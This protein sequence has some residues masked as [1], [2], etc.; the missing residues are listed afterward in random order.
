MTLIQKVERLKGFEIFI[1]SAKKINNSNIL[2]NFFLSL[3][4]NTS[5]DDDQ[6]YYDKF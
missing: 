2:I 3:P 6:V 1:L 5:L 4:R